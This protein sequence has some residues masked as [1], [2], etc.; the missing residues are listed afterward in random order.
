MIVL[1]SQTTISASLAGQ[2]LFF[3]L[4]LGREK[5]GFWSSLNPT[6]VLTRHMVTSQVCSIYGPMRLN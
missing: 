1:H 2:T 4:S 3:S 6:I 5:K